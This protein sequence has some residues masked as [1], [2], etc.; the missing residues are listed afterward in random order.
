MKIP[1]LIVLTSLLSLSGISQGALEDSMALAEASIVRNYNGVKSNLPRVVS[2]KK[3]CPTPGNQDSTNACVGFAFG[4]GAMT[5]MG[6]IQKGYTNK[7]CINAERF[8]PW[9]IYNQIQKG[10]NGASNVDAANFLENKGICLLNTYQD[11]KHQAPKQS[12][13]DTV[14]TFKVKEWAIL[15]KKDDSPEEKRSKIKKALNAK[16]PIV[17]KIAMFESFREYQYSASRT[18]WKRPKQ[19]A[20]VKGGAHSLVIIGYNDS[21]QTFEV[22]NSW[23]TTWGNGGFAEIAYEE[24][25]LFK[26]GFQLIPPDNF[27]TILINENTDCSQQIIEADLPEAIVTSPSKKKSSKT[28]INREKVQYIDLTGEFELNQIEQNSEISFPEATIWNKSIKMYELEQP[29]IREALFQVVGKNIPVGKYV[30]IFSCDPKKKVKLHYP[31]QEGKNYAN[32]ISSSGVEIYYPAYNKV[33]KLSHVGT[34]FWCVLFS[35][36]EIKNIKYKLNTINNYTTSNFW[37]ILEETFGDLLIKPELIEYK[38]NQMFASTTTTKHKG[39]IMPIILKITIT[40][41]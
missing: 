33:L 30:Y 41:N 18:F 24:M 34:E 14:T 23:G 9:F 39:V 12:F 20:Y 38:P 5:I 15:F 2:L 13:L 26:T 25:D 31:K 36:E 27:S 37:A 17:V 29:A 8:S 16:L 3:Y 22:M 19:R 6:A 28:Y 32:F 4:Y 40:F 10:W 11:R 1:I 35:D 21:R 7:A